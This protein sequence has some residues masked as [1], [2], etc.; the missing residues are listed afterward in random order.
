M[1]KLLIAAAALLIPASAFASPEPVAPQ[2]ADSGKPAISST[3]TSAAASSTFTPIAGRSF[4]VQLSGTASAV[5][6]LERQLDGSTWTPITVTSNGTTTIMH[7]WTYSTPLSE[8]ETESQANVP[9]RVDCG[10][11]LG[12]YTSGTLNVRI[13]Q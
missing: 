12:S 8:D 1:R 11:S 2:Y 10:A 4:H 5:C 7:N 6:V 13:S 3:I 9:Y